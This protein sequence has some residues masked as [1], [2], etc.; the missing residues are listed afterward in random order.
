MVN[1]VRFLAGPNGATLYLLHGEERGQGILF[2][3][4]SE[5]GLSGWNSPRRSR[6]GD[7]MALPPIPWVT[8][9]EAISSSLSD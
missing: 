9:R 5:G 4:G 7:A 2:L 3:H 1:D 6:F 8:P